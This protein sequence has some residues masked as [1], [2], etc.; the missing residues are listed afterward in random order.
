MGAMTV[1]TIANKKAKENGENGT[2]SSKAR[3]ELT[4]AGPIIPPTTLGRV[5]N[6]LNSNG[7]QALLYLGFVVVFQ[8]LAQ[9]MRANEEFQL[10]KLVQDRLI[11]NHFDSSHNTF[12]SV[13]RVADIYE[14]GNNVLWPGLLGDTGPCDGD[15]VGVLGSA[16]LCNDHTWPDGDGSFHLR[17][18]TPYTVAELVER[19][20]QFDWTEGIL[21]R[22]GRSAPETCQ[23][24]H[25][26]GACYPALSKG[27]GSRAPY[28]F[29][30]TH[31]AEPLDR[32]FVYLT[33][34][35]LG[36]DA[37]MTSANFASLQG[38]STGG[39]A[40]L[41]IPFFADRYLPPEEGAAS[42]IS[43]F[44]Q[45]Y[46]NTTNERTARA[47][48]VRTST[49][50]RYLKQLCD[51]GTNGDGSGALTGVVRAH[52]ETFWNDLKRAHYIDA[53]TRVVS[54][55]LQLKS[56]H[57]GVAYRITLMFEL[58][59]VGAILPSYDIETRLLD[60]ALAD[61]M[62]VYASIG[63][64]MVIFFSLLEGVEL[65]KVGGAYLS[66]VWNVMD[67]ANFFFYYL[68]FAQVR[69]VNDNLTP[70]CDSYLCS[71]VGY[72]DDW[73]LMGEYRQAKL[74][75]SLC[76]CIQL[77][78]ILKFTDAFVPKLGLATKVLRKCALD[79]LFFGGTFIISM[80][81][82][83]MMLYVQLGPVML[84]F[85]D[86]FGAFIALFR[87][88]F[89]DFDIDEIL[90]NSPSYLNAIFFLCYLFVA[91]F[92]MLSMFLAILAEA[93]VNLNSEKADI[94]DAR[95]LQDPDFSEFVFEYGVLAH[96]VNL[97]KR[98]VTRSVAHIRGALGYKPTANADGASAAGPAAADVGTEKATLEQVFGVI[99]EM[100]RELRELRELRAPASAPPIAPAAL[101][102]R[103]APGLSSACETSSPM[104]SPAC[105]IAS[106]S[107]AASPGKAKAPGKASMAHLRA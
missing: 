75:L 25:Q 31:P 40:A 23:T 1:Q 18:A 76:V 60:T 2:Q 89:G 58:T 69:A 7:F 11:E 5:L 22:Q 28:G 94:M 78:K 42:D 52:I 33:R 101:A 36:A 4:I 50:G 6:L 45:Y 35:E 48:C 46:V 14:W 90:D 62:N 88:L 27:S 91:I 12:E 21:I 53:K 99:L 65:V 92:I 103:T 15:A 81:A 82:F 16:K 95:R 9:T 59:S 97:T 44:R 68:V 26:L 63:L 24:T 8:L 30:Y 73:R 105:T 17:S 47:F 19:M 41:V 80:L 57:L 66:D 37:E 100:Q 98:G 70:K 67:W 39:Y 71:E 72:F 83:S 29:N 32:P 74:F 79:L 87:A 3:P 51:P 77:F 56:N 10:N 55:V 54:L 34:D 13:R 61:Q 20:D 102:V 38:Y 93:Q 85:H 96:G 43:D 86:Q 84:H 49:N 104:L 64:A 107:D 106:G